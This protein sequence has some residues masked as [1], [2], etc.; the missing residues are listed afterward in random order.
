MDLASLMKSEALI[1]LLNH[2]YGV[3]RLEIRLHWEDRVDTLT[4]GDIMEVTREVKI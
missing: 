3:F 4:G 1:R 2:V